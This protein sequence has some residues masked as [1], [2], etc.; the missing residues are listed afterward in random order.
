MISEESLIKSL[1]INSS[2][3]IGDDAA[4]LPSLSSDQYCITKDLLIED[5]HF[6]LAYF[7]AKD[8]A[9]KALHVNLSDLAAMGAT[10]KYILCGVSIPIEREH[11]VQSFLQNLL[12]SSKEAKV[13]LIGGDITKSTNKFHISITAI[14]ICATACVKYRN[15]AQH[16]DVICV[17]GNLGWAHLGMIAFEKSYPITLEYK[18]SCLRPQA[19]IREGIWLTQQS[20]VTSMMDISDGL[21]IDLKK[22]CEGSSVGGVIDVEK[23][24][25]NDAFLS[26]CN[27]LNLDPINVALTG[28]EDYG[29]LFTVKSESFADFAYVFSSVFGYP[30]KC[31]GS[32]TC[33]SSIIFK[34]N[35]RL[36]DLFVQPFTHF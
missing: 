25:F 17:A 3:F 31:L 26:A 34:K 36:I 20:S 5:V 28:G 9:H 10:P 23:I 32:I 15:T 24:K 6:R 33:G 1:A 18:M 14:G 22:L 19:K 8:L 4:I 2:E 13:T 12:I 7:S 21:Y 35:N 16:N 30:I 27:A 29:L 11:Y